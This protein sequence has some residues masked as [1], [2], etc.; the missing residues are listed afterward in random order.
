MWLID[1]AADT[2]GEPLLALAFGAF[3]VAVIV[4][5]IWCVAA[6]IEEVREGGLFGGREE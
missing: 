3:L 2:K 5:L 6:D 1:W 4:T